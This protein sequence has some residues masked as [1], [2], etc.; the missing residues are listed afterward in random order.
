VSEDLT[1][2]I[3]G[4][5]RWD[6]SQDISGFTAGE[7]VDAES[8]VITWTVALLQEHPELRKRMDWGRFRS[9]VVEN[10]ADIMLAGWDEDGIFRV[11]QA[12]LEGK[13][14]KG[15]VEFNGLGSGRPTAIRA[16]LSKIFNEL[17]GKPVKS[18][19]RKTIRALDQWI[20]AHKWPKPVAEAAR[21]L[22]RRM[23]GG[24]YLV[25]LPGAGASHGKASGTVP[26][27]VRDMDLP[28]TGTISIFCYL[29][30]TRAVIWLRV[31]PIT[32]GKEARETLRALCPERKVS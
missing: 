13:S 4:P 27:E 5:I 21:S 30:E 10:P 29:H 1:A 18:R 17:R 28:G 3:V 2:E 22:V 16:Q 12:I 19:E 31:N 15:P 24:T 32:A 26:A 9:R 20:K 14:G 8:A 23:Q 25:L 6:V 11:R 7:G